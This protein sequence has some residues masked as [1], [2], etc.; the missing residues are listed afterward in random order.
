MKASKILGIIVLIIA[1]PL[2]I[3]RFY[4]LATHTSR[5]K[6][7]IEKQTE[8]RANMKQAFVR[9]CYTQKMKVEDEQLTVI[10]DTKLPKAQRKEALRQ[11]WMLCDDSLFKNDFTIQSVI[12]PEG[13]E[14]LEEMNRVIEVQCSEI[15]EKMQNGTERL[16]RE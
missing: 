12:T 11:L 16:S 7:R 14:R 13:R 3:F 10:K 6:L 8:Q 15:V 5:E 2:Y 1:L 4:R 9:M